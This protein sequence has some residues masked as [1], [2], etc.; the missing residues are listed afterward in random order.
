MVKSRVATKAKDKTVMLDLDADVVEAL[1]DI[2]KLA[3]VSPSQVVSVMLSTKVYNDKIY[4]EDRL[5]K[6]KR[7]KNVSIGLGGK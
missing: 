7:T 6:T 4:Q 3:G 1:E 2:A 5:K